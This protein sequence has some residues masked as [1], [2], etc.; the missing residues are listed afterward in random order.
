M[1]E[2]TFEFDND[3]NIQYTGNSVK[4][5]SAHFPIKVRIKDAKTKQETV[6]VIMAIRKYKKLKLIMN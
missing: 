6:R 4:V 5:N 2:I 3:K 1:T